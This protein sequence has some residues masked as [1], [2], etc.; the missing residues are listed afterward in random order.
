MFFVE[1]WV[2]IG[3]YSLC[4][5]WGCQL[6]RAE[7]EA[8]LMLRCCWVREGWKSH[9]IRTEKESYGNYEGKKEE[10]MNGEEDAMCAKDRE[11]IKRKPKACQ[12]ST[13]VS[14]CPVV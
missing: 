8:E 4:P 1:T 14:Y 9:C 6:P 3:G 11:R 10:D 7:G 12:I 2:L 5:E 13:S